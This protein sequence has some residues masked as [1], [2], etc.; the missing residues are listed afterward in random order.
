MVVDKQPILEMPRW[1]STGT[2]LL[3]SQTM[4]LF[5]TAC[6]NKDVRTRAQTVLVNGIACILQYI[7]P[8]FVFLVQQPD[9]FSYCMMLFDTA[10]CNHIHVNGTTASSCC[11]HL[12]GGLLHAFVQVN[13]VTQIGFS[14]AFCFRHTQKYQMDTF[15]PML[16][17]LAVSLGLWVEQVCSR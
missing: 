6:C 11:W 12:G 14:S 1:H 7:T 9:P 17:M 13:S 15:P 5:F 10:R 2:I 3:W 4:V 8:Y 16:T